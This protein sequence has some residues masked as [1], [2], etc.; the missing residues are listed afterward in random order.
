MGEAKQQ[1]F[2]SSTWKITAGCFRHPRAVPSGSD[3]SVGG[4]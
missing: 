2:A 4:P 3:P 1:V